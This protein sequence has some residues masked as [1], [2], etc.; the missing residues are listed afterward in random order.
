MHSILRGV[1]CLVVIIIAP[2]LFSGCTED[3]KPIETV[4]SL[5]TITI[6]S[7]TSG[8]QRLFSGV[9][10]SRDSSTLS[11]EVGGR[12]KSI[13]VDIGDKVQMGQ[14]L[15]VLDKEPYELDVDAA[16]AELEKAKAHVTT[17]FADFERYDQ[18]YKK[19]VIAKSERDNVKFQYSSAKSDVNVLTA[20]LNIAR[21]DLRMT[22]MRAPYDG[23]ISMRKA[24]AHEEIKPGQQVLDIDAHGVL[25]VQLAIPESN[26]AMLHL[27]LQAMISFP[28]LKGKQVKGVITDIGS[29]AIQAN[30][31]PVN[32]EILNPPDGIDPGMSA[33]VSIFAES[34]TQRTGFLVPAQAILPDKGK[35]QGF[36]YIFD[37]STSAVKRTPVYVSGSIN[38]MA[39]VQ[40][41]LTEGDIIAVAGVSFLADGMKVKLIK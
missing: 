40:G 41:G 28:T 5:K 24:E 1:Y 33:E 23:S 6:G 2:L 11:F 38:N 39:L 26:K 14:V 36:V 3:P 32:V 34:N 29:A 25:E 16:T 8:E 10:K 4:R 31:F 21:H 37:S 20:K 7:P 9:V 27:G 18:L 22:T 17:T 35:A 13:N 12:I 30:S 19:N 15:A